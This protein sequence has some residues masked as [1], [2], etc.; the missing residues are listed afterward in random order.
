VFQLVPADGGWQETVLHVFNGGAGGATSY[1]SLVA[2]KAGNLYGTNITGGSG[3]AGTVFELVKPTSGQGGWTETVLA[4]FDGANGSSP[5]AN[6]VFAGHGKLVGTTQS[7]GTGYGTVF[8]VTPPAAGAGSWTLTT[9]YS[10][11]TMEVGFPQSALLPGPRDVLYGTTTGSF[12]DPGEVF[13]V[14]P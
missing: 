7:G 12:A 5:L 9:L 4:N 6:V 1:S 11:P 14:T 3:G 8:I 10:F 13:A 2:D